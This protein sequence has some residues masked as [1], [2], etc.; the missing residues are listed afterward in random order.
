MNNKY[1]FHPSYLFSAALPIVRL[2]KQS[3]EFTLFCPVAEGGRRLTYAGALLAKC[4]NI[5]FTIGP[6]LNVSRDFGFNSK[7]DS[8]QIANF[9][10]ELA[11]FLK[12]H[13]N[14]DFNIG[15]YMDIIHKIE[16]KSQKIMY[17]V[18]SSIDKLV[19]NNVSIYTD[20]MRYEMYGHFLSHFSWTMPKINTNKNKYN[21]IKQVKIVFIDDSISFGRIGYAISIIKRILQT[22]VCFYVDSAPLEKW[23][24]LDSFLGV[25]P[26]YW[27]RSKGRL[28]EDIEI[29]NPRN[30]K[31]TRKETLPDFKVKKLISTYKKIMIMWKEIRNY[32]NFGYFKFLESISPS[33]VLVLMGLYSRSG[34]ERLDF[35][36]ICYPMDYFRM[37]HR[38]IG[39]SRSDFWITNQIKHTEKPHLPNDIEVLRMD[40][41]SLIE[42]EDALIRTKLR[43]TSRIYYHHLHTQTQHFIENDN[44]RHEIMDYV[45]LKKGFK[46]RPLGLILSQLEVDKKDCFLEVGHPLYH[47]GH[48]D[49]IIKLN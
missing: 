1:E 42:I 15:Y 47:G 20:E 32:D 12:C 6:S 16:W 35:F 38:S 34:R 13:C 18:K 14:H 7:T 10:Y 30:L 40:L 28:M 44:T 25:R 9:V 3:T 48:L 5:D 29:M 43:H 24:K 8:N 22:N 23:Y 45:N 37:L 41:N 33:D 4:L 19:M 21:Q 36:K 2:A 17:D 27:R 49:E 39:S 31:E 26:D 11:S 46:F